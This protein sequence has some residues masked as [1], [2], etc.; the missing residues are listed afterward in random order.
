MEGQ[1]FSRLRNLIGKSQKDL[2]VMLGVSRKAVESYEQGW[3][4]IP[5][6]VERMIYYIIFKFNSKS[7]LEN[8]P[9]WEIRS[10][11]EKGREKCPAWISKEGVF[12]WFISGKLCSAYR[13]K[14]TDFY[15]Q[16]CPVFQEHLQSLSLLPKE[17][18]CQ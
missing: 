6:H 17:A 15:C 14:G 13:E 3:R 10:C 11:P 8:Q 16:K 1:E 18:P 7:L 4:R 12:C 9:C 5:A 2:A